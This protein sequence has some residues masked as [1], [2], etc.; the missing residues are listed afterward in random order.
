M[1][2]NTLELVGVLFVFLMEKGQPLFELLIYV[3]DVL[4]VPLMHRHQSFVS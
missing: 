1:L 3:L 2:R 4:M